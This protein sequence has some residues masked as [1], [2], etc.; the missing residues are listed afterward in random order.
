MLVKF[1]IVAVPNARV[2]EDG[3]CVTVGV[4]SSIW[5]FPEVTA[6]IFVFDI[7][8]TNPVIEVAVIPVG[9]TGVPRT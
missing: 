4:C 8:G 6:Q 5:S 1:L 3:D 9:T 2:V 7:F